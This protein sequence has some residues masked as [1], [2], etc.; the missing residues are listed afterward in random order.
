MKFALT[1]ILIFITLI[2]FSQQ[3]IGVSV[4]SNL[5]SINLNLNFQKVIKGP[6]LLYSGISFGSFGK[7]ENLATDTYLNQNS[8]YGSPF[9]SVDREIR[10]V[11]GTYILCD[12]NTKGSG[13]IASF[14]LGVFK[15]FQNFHG[16]RFNVNQEFGWVKSYVSAFYRHTSDPVGRR[17]VA[18]EIW[19]PIGSLSFE[20]YHTI[21]LSGRNTFVWGFRMPYHYSLDRGRFQPRNMSDIFYNFRPEI[22]VGMTRSIGKCD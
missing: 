1:A 21:R 17:V 13:L 20:L 18:S 14:G 15:E 3:R 16:I 10:D 7:S 19:H 22:S 11:N 8:G 4:N 2:S 12:I 5:A 6:I 9:P